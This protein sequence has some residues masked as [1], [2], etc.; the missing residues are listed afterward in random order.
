M[1]NMS[2]L[3]PRM[4]NSMMKKM[5]ITNDTIPAKRVI[6]ELDDKKIIIDNPN[7]TEISFNG[8]KTYQVMGDMHEES[9]VIEIPESDI[10]MVME[11]AKID[12]ATA[13]NLLEK[14]E[15]DIAKA[16]SFANDK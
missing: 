8:Q 6:I 15:G 9:A 11:S 14:S 5:G 3:D 10:Q 16:I 4:V 12:K 13:K 1:P 7:V 2:G